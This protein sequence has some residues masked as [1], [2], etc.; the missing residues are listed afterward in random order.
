M[1]LERKVLLQIRLLR[2]GV[3]RRRRKEEG[4]ARLIEGRL[5]EEH[6]E[7]EVEGKIN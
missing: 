7:K 4:V 3:E 1:S 5:G 2:K 6:G